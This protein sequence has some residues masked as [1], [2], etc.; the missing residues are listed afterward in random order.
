MPEINGLPTIEYWLADVREHVLASAPDMLSIL[1]MYEG[2]ARFG[3][4]YIAFDLERLA[5][6]ATVLEVGAGSLLLSCQ[7]VREGFKV[8]ALEPVGDGFSH[9]E[10]LRELILERAETFG[11][12]PQMLNQRAEELSMK[13]YF[14]YAF[15]INVME[16]VSDVKTV[17]TNIGASLRPAASYRFT[18][19]N[20]LFPYEPHF[21][22][23]T[24]F[25]K[26]ITEKIFKNK[27]FRNSKLPDPSGTWKSLNW[28]TVCQVSKIAG[29]T[30]ELKVVFNRMFLVSTLERIGSDQEFALRRS[31]WVRTFILSLIKLRIHRLAG[32]VPVALQPVIDCTLTRREC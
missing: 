3:R 29:R 15:S 22:I 6:G 17:I 24:F 31:R 32:F 4:R 18:C 1:D 9:F 11:C 13:D 7:L 5:K 8:L 16:H 30:S 23:P 10:R 14:D 25:S 20:Y 2:E 28:I 26:K 19:P 27:I 21:N 12:V